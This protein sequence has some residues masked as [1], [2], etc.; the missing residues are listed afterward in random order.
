MRFPSHA[1]FV[2]SQAH[3]PADPSVVDR[4]GDSIWHISRNDNLYRVNDSG[5]VSATVC[6]SS[7][8]AI[9]YVWNIG[10]ESG[11]NGPFDSVDDAMD[12][13]DANVF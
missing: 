6:Y 8:G 1:D 3:C 2:A 7:S 11:W 13:A 12:D 9:G 10:D 5:D 4:G